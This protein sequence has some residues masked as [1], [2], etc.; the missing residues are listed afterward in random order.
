MFFR[1]SGDPGGAWSGEMFFCADGGSAP[2]GVGVVRWNVLCAGGGS[3]PGGDGQV[4]C[5]VRR[6]RIGSGIAHKAG[7]DALRIESEKQ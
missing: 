5:F 7:G 1:G 4:E 2:A 3:A 6:R